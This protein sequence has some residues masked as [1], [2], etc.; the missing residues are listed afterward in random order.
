MSSTEQQPQPY[1][2]VPSAYGAA[3]G[4][5]QPG[6]IGLIV[7]LVLVLV[8]AIQQ[9]VFYFLPTI[10]SDFGA[11][12]AAIQTPFAIVQALLA[13]AALVLGIVGITKRGAPKGAAGAATA[14]S[15]ATLF[16]MMLGYVLGFAVSAL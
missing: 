15:A 11:S 5:N 3:S 9:G 8:G 16:S 12:V 7:A 6:L 10:M 1:A 4:S 13:I 14:L 2:P